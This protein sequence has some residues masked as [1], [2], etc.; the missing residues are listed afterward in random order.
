MPL[1]NTCIEYDGKQ[2]FECPSVWNG[3]S[4]KEHDLFKN[5]WC[6]KN[7]IKLIRIPYYHLKDL[8]LKDLIPETSIFLIT[9]GENND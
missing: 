2:H 6:L 1:Y 7:N 9:E 3:K 4:I 5:N 8:T